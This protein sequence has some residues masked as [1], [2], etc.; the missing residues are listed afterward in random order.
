VWMVVCT[1]R[2][3]GERGATADD[4]AAEIS[5]KC[6]RSAVAGEGELSV[7][8]SVCLF[9]SLSLSVRVSSG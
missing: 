2:R 7:C 8:L 5:T 6:V 4:T 9:V 1:Y 3:G